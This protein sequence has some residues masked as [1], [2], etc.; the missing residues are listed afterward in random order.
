MFSIVETIILGETERE[1]EAKEG[2]K[3][4]NASCQCLRDRK[5]R[6]GK[7]SYFSPSSSLSLTLSSSFLLDDVSMRKP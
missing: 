2:N 5:T 6:K 7:N 4:R 3:K 1:K